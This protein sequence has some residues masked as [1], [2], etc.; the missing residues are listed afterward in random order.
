MYHGERW[1]RRKAGT[2]SASACTRLPPPRLCLRPQVLA[3]TDRSS[4]SPAEVL[5][6]LRDVAPGR[7]LS[8]AMAPP[9]TDEQA[10]PLL[11]TIFSLLN[12]DQEPKPGVGA[13]GNPG[14][15]SAPAAAAT[16]GMP[17]S[18][19][20]AGPACCSPTASAQEW[21]R[22]LRS[23]LLSEVVPTLA[24]LQMQLQ[25]QA[26]TA[27]AVAQGRS[28]PAS[29]VP[30]SPLADAF[31]GASAPPLLAPTEG[32][33]AAS[34]PPPTAGGGRSHAPPAAAL[35]PLRS[36]AAAV[37]LPPYPPVGA[38]GAQQHPA[39]RAS[40]TCEAKAAEPSAP[41]EPRGPGSSQTLV[42][43]GRGGAPPEELLCPITTD[44]MDDP[45]VAADGHSYERAAIARWLA[46]R[47][48][49]PATSP[50]TGAV[51]PHTGL[52]PNYALRKIIRD[53]REQHGE[54][55]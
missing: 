36:P 27:A 4:P 15:S 52:T 13:P 7:L 5:C 22:T 6:A 21:A 34:A 42:P 50:L 29:L 37:R 54:C 2:A 16:S 41:V 44:L 10:W 19:M 40:G 33:P 26:A 45:V 30:A 46:E 51:L 47:R 18:R 11:A 9:L 55:D 20:P 31:A 49:A 24:A 17:V 14:G 35:P 53:W 38:G 3:G 23:H 1:N 39:D 43:P 28:A 8:P 12:W 32:P 25:A 48:R